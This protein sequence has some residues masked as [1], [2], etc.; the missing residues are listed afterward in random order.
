[1]VESTAATSQRRT[2]ETL[3]ASFSPVGLRYIAAEHT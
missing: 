3:L 1:M 2:A